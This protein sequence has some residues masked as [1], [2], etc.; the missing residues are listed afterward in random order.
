MSWRG[1]MTPEMAA[2]RA[3]EPAF[4]GLA[5][6][7][8][9]ALVV[10]SGLDLRVDAAAP[11]HACTVARVADTQG[12]DGIAWARQVH[13]DTVLRVEEPGCAGEA[14]ALWTTVPGVG[15]MGRSADCPI[16]LLAGH[17]GD[18]SPI[19][20]MA[21]A[22]WRS[23]VTGITT[24]LLADMVAAGA[25]PDRLSAVVAPSAGPCCYEVGVEV[26]TA[27]LAGIGPHA[28]DFFIERDGAFVFDLWAANSDALSR[29]GVVARIDGRCTI[30]G[31]G[32]PSYRRDGAAAERFGVVVGFG[33]R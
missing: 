22:S 14:D 18:G 29:G 26:R 4:P 2:D 23:T 28:S 11:E 1:W 17:R 24:R 6:P 13:G 15:V 25:D 32:F 3:F 31:D 5:S 20:G 7:W 19:W 16:V 12:L 27:A 30:C 9:S 8:T 21:H 10:D 33:L